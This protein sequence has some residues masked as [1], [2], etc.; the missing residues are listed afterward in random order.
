MC[1]II[2]LAFVSPLFM[3]KAGG[4]V[5]D[6]P[7]AINRTGH[8]ATIELPD[9]AF[10]QISLLDFDYSTFDF[11]HY[12][13]ELTFDITESDSIDHGRL[14]IDS[15]WL[16]ILEPTVRNGVLSVDYVR[17]EINGHQVEYFVPGD[18]LMVGTIIVPKGTVSSIDAM[19]CKIRS[20]NN[21][22]C[23]SLTVKRTSDVEFKNCHVPSLNVS[24]SI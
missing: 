16:P 11:D 24:Y 14:V 20:I 3:F 21:F 12:S 7:I 9:S 5:N 22:N 17:K 10:S 23:D 13:H 2:V 4:T 1:A 6:S 18:N 8:T 15:S 19:K